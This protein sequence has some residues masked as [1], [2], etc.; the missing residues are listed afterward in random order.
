MHVVSSPPPPPL[1]A[2]GGAGR[3]RDVVIATKLYVP[4]PPERPVLRP[5]LEALLAGGER[6]RVTLVVAPAGWGK[7]SLVSQWLRGRSTSAGWVSLDRGDDDVTRFWRYLLS[8]LEHAVPGSAA[9]ALERL[10]APGSDVLRDVLPALLNELSARTH[11]V[12]VV[13]DDYHAITADA[14]H[15]S[16]RRLVEHAPDQLHL[17]ILSR[18]D[19]PLPTSRLRV[20]GRLVELRAEHLRFT[21]DEADELLRQ[22]LG[23]RLPEQDVSRLVA[24]TEGWVAGLQLAGLRLA[25]RPDAGSRSEF[26]ERFTGADRHVVD[27]LGEEVL[28]AQ[29]EDVRSFL[30]ETAV[31][32]RISADLAAAVTGREDSRA[33]LDR[34]HR[35]NLFLTPLDDEQHWFRY[36]QLFRGILQHELARV[37]PRRP[38]ELHRRAASWFAQAGEA[39]EA[40]GHAIA[41]GDSALAAALIAEGW[42]EQFNAGHLA[43]VR[44]WLDAL[45]P[46]LVAADA[47][48]GAGRVWLALDAGR[49]AEADAALAPAERAGPDEPEVRA[50]RALLAY[51]AG[52]VRRALALFE[53]LGP[54]LVDPF[55]RTVRDLVTGVCLLW[56]AEFDRATVSLRAALRTAQEEGNRLAQVY[57]LGCLAL[58]S[59]ERGELVQADDVLA[60]AAQAA[61]PIG[62]QHFVAMFPAL[63]ASRLA[64]ARG[65]PPGREAAAAIELGRRGAGRVEL[66]AALVSGGAVAEARA[67][68]KECPDPGPLVLEW[69]RVEQRS[70]PAEPSAERLT[71]RELAI[72]RLLP[73]TL[74]QRQ[75]A[76]SLFVTPNTLKTHLRSI[77]RKLGAESRLDAVSRARALDLL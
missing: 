68:L 65:T 38:A 55:L 33:V 45:P 8:A 2:A 25:D 75:I 31:L 34:I 20:A 22:A 58:V 28:A 24:R 13:L 71:E 7:S 4:P 14:V 56:L 53:V 74:T 46:E 5:R 10:E 40:I 67:L 51:K 3:P 57:A 11:A 59:V 30:L 64:A 76:G 6:A 12:L 60:A 39:A 41:S 44:G 26:I 49:L 37:A 48:L 70:K 63:A 69:L 36:H 27:Y 23:L 47:R 16:L 1:Q 32:D 62:R 43:T 15:E 72:V 29:P 50:L 54:S 66:A 77:Y 21:V 35:A 52:D 18:S 61:E 9:G 73:T 17:V 42:R 19:P